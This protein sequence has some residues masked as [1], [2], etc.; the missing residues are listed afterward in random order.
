M[1]DHRIYPCTN[2]REVKLIGDVRNVSVGS[3]SQGCA[4]AFYVLPSYYESESGSV[5][6]PPEESNENNLIGV[7]ISL[8]GWLP[9]QRDILST[10][11][12][13]SVC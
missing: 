13:S 11:V 3:L 8:S 4:M 7:F 5:C 12:K 1:R 10:V 2:K 6:S 9:F